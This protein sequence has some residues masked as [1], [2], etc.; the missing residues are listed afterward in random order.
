MLKGPARLKTAEQYLRHVD[1]PDRRSELVRGL[2]VEKP[3]KGGLRGMTSATIGSILFGYVRE[4]D[5]GSVMLGTGCVVERGP[6]TVRAPDISFLT[7]RRVPEGSPEGYIEGAPDL[8]VEVITSFDIA[9]DIQ[10]KTQEYLTAGAQEVWLAYPES[11]TVV[12]CRKDGAR[13]HYQEND[14]IQTEALLPGFSIAV[15]EFFE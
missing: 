4:H 10:Q 2:V 3:L 1:K 11:R 5:L 15:R 8:A 6:D 9:P 14:T 13:T 12:A 7:S